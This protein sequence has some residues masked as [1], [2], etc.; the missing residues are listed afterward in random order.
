MTP[1]LKHGDKGES[2]AVL[3]R[4]LIAAGHPIAAD[5]DFGDKTEAALLA[6]QQ[7][8]GLVAD[9]IYGPA[10][11]AAIAHVSTK[12]Y[13]KEADIR[14][15]AELLQVEPAAVKAVVQVESAGTGYLKDGRVKILFERHIFY[16]ELVKAKGKAFAESMTAEAPDVCH[17]QPGGYRGGVAEYPRLARAMGIDKTVGMAAASWGLFQIMGFNH[18][19]A[20][21]D[22][23][24]EFVDAMKQSEGQQLQAFAR[25]VKANKAMHAALQ[26]KD[27]AKFA[28]LYNGPAYKRHN[29]DS[30]LAN[31]YER[32]A[33]QQKTPPDSGVEKV[34]V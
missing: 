10:T 16:K 32:Y 30:K 20:G 14:Y 3:Q 28:S 33:A 27:W 6:Y 17:A 4:A 11:A 23:V 13:L 18:Q 8:R 5:G 1:L 19:A 21:F 2:V 26:K 22:S 15:A 29:Y 12:G 34:A 31:A 9:G 25:F 7:Q 24:D